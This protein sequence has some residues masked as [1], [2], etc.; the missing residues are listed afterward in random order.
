MQHLFFS[1]HK[2]RFLVKLETLRVCV[3][4]SFN[5]LKSSKMASN[6]LC[7][8]PQKS[9]LSL[10]TLVK[11]HLMWQNVFH[12]ILQSTCRRFASRLLMVWACESYLEAILLAFQFGQRS[13]G[14]RTAKASNWNAS[15]ITIENDDE[16]HFWATAHFR[17]QLSI[18]HTHTEHKNETKRW[19]GMRPSSR[20]EAW[21]ITHTHYQLSSS[22]L[23]SF[24][25]WSFFEC[26]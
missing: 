19:M 1:I 22:T 9:F 15:F 16:F 7:V 3:F 11:R 8:R 4:P 12:S 20:R 13:K 24:F 21:F 2:L 6:S 26:P 5:Q 18:A 25:S 14:K 10:V 17:H 23:S